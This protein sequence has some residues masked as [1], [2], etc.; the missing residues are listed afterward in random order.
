MHL[1]SYLCTYLYVCLHV[2]MYPTA[3]DDDVAMRH[4]KSSESVG[5]ARTPRT[6]SHANEQ[7]AALAAA[8]KR[9]LA[10]Q[11]RQ[12]QWEHS[13]L[14]NG[15]H[16]NARVFMSWS[17]AYPTG[18]CSVIKYDGSDDSKKRKTLRLRTVVLELPKRKHAAGAKT[19]LVPG[20]AWVCFVP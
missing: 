9:E 19:L 10:Q 6:P 1:F 3:L 5:G 14:G 18:V 4:A 13:L 15:I 8:T 2:C 17:K 12:Q 16:T 7:T 20:A 11:E